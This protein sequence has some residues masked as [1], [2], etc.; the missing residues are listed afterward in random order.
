M[1]KDYICYSLRGT[2]QNKNIVVVKVDKD[3][4]IVMMKNQII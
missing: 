4:S 1:Q 2:I 3:S